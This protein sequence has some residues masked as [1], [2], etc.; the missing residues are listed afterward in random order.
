MT[1]KNGYSFWL[2]TLKEILSKG[3][4]TKTDFGYI[5]I[6]IQKEY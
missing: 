5:T 2:L 6:K 1:I 3:E 4:I